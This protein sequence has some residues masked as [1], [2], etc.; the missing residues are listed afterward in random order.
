MAA[1]IDSAAP[2]FADPA[3]CKENSRAH[4]TVR[5]VYMIR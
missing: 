1:Q 5:K 2:R 4:E 3:G